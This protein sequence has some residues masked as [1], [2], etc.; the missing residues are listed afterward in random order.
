M[1]FRP[2]VAA[3]SAGTVIAVAACTPAPQSAAPESPDRSV[4]SPAAPPVP[5]ATSHSALPEAAESAGLDVQVR[6]LEAETGAVITVAYSDGTSAG[7]LQ[8]VTAWSTAKVPLAVAAYR[9]DPAN[10][11][12][13]D[14]AIT[15]SDNAAAHTLW[16]NL[17][18][19]AEA[20][21][22]V[23]EV[24]TEAGDTTRVPAQPPR[25]GFTAFGQAQWPPLAQANFAAALP[26]L[27]GSEAVLDPMGRI[28]PA[29][30]YG[31]GL[32]PGAVFKGGW[33]PDEQGRYLTR[34]F[35]IVDGEGVAV[36]V[37]PADG[38]YESGQ[39]ILDRIALE[40]VG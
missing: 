21:A 34:Q 14:A 35:G 26:G 2:A 27:A 40:I 31:L 30:S 5:P 11:P 13:I 1:R 28:D 38:T 18:G 6:A 19:G 32:L 29:Q 36:A 33:G 7:T 9:A 12:L 15:T 16:E 17:G 39:R 22:A 23:E 20:A 3:L 24:L 10:E 4:V 25:A 37:M 8:D